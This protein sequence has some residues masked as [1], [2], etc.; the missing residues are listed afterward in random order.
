M[1]DSAQGL[2]V[3]LAVRFVGAATYPA[4]RSGWGALDALALLIAPF[5]TPA[6][7]DVGLSHSI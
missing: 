6:S 3:G 4:G 5:A 2:V 7:A 1:L